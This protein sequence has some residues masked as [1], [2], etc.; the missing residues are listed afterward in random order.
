M[1]K[2]KNHELKQR[3]SRAILLSKSVI[4]GVFSDLGDKIILGKHGNLCLWFEIKYKREWLNFAKCK[5][6]FKNSLTVYFTDIFF[7]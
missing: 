1:W 5:N 6:I 3:G 2:K 4:R 7:L